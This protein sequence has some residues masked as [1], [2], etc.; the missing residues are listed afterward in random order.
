M[1]CGSLSTLSVSNQSV[2]IDGMCEATLKMRNS[3][4]SSK[5]QNRLYAGLAEHVVLLFCIA[6]HAIVSESDTEALVA[7]TLAAA[8][9]SC[10]ILLVLPGPPQHFWQG[11]K[12]L[13]HACYITSR[14]TPPRV[15]AAQRWSRTHRASWSGPK[16]WQHGPHPRASGPGRA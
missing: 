8:L 6:C 10:T 5:L 13:P 14:V 4:T 3:H 9:L 2:Q 1:V 12:H 15:G 7:A 11:L 16:P